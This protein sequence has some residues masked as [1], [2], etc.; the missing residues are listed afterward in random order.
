MVKYLVPAVPFPETHCSG[1]PYGT[2]YDSKCKEQFSIAYVHAIATAARCK[3][4]EIVVDDESVDATIRQVATHV[5]LDYVNLDIQLKC[6]SQAVER[7]EY[8]AW[9]LRKKNYLDLASTRR[10]APIILI[11]LQV[12]KKFEDWLLQ[13]DK[14]LTLAKSAYW[15]SIRGFPDLPEGQTQETVKLPKTQPFNVEHL[16]DIL[17]RVGD[18]GVP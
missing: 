14:S 13:D 12:P 18:G 2:L 1:L 15:T 5:M 7:D 11:V 6:T 10:G 4:E 17:A 3:L 9:P 16:L 8:I